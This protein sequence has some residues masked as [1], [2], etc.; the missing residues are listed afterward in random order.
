MFTA[1]FQCLAVAFGLC[2]IITPPLIRIASRKGWL[3]RPGFRKIHISPRPRLGG[4]GIFWGTWLSFLVFALTHPNYIPYESIRPLWALFGASSLVWLLGLYDD[5]RGANAWEKLAVQFVAA[6]W[7]VS[8]GIGIRLVNNL[9]GGDF[10]LHSEW[11]VWGITIFWIVVVTN[12]I[13]LIDGLDGLA[14]GV[15]AITSLTI[16]FI[17]KD[18]GNAPHVP[19]FALC[20]AGACA[21]FLL[22]N[23]A[24]ARIFLGDSGSLFLGFVLSCL[25][26]LG[27]TKR[28]TAIV[29]YGPPLVLALPVADTV[30]A[31]L[32]R[33][34]R[35]VQQGELSRTHPS[36]V[37]R[38]VVLRLREVFQADQEHIHHALIQ[39]GLSHRRVVVLL[40]CVTA[41][42][43]LTAY[44]MA[45]Y[46]HLL[47][48]GVTFLLLSGGIFW[49]RYKV[50]RTPPRV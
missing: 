20:L 44:R 9:V 2:V 31:I 26:I 42:L 7:V 22:Y 15:C 34:L 23:F 28:S 24:P 25:S 21:G 14:S 16:F 49:L 29:M 50:R 30:F 18:L 6:I 10:I 45:V 8:Q 19:F 35:R 5:L 41:V 4:V 11:L 1:F 43:G 36:H 3:D 48:T 47:G 37:L 33:F 38:N 32:R 13:N 12:S 39:I 17:A 46:N 40:Y 27:T